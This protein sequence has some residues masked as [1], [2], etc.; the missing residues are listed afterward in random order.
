MRYFYMQKQTKRKQEVQRLRIWTASSNT[1]QSTS[2][3]C[4]PFVA[5][6]YV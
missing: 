1:E 2:V 5:L 6:V 4:V 3:N